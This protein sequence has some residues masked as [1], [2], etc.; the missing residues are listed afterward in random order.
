MKCIRLLAFPHIL[1]STYLIGCVVDLRP[2]RM[3]DS[4]SVELDWESG[5]EE[6]HSV[7]HLE[8]EC[9]SVEEYRRVR[10]P[11]KLKHTT[12]M[13]LMPWTHFELR[14]TV[15]DELGASWK[16]NPIKLMTRKAGEID[17]YI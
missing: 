4:E 2:A 6:S 13:G 1:T 10:L 9:S 14:V 3:L 16:S 17:V 15:V 11:S 8:I 5:C 7:R 12:L